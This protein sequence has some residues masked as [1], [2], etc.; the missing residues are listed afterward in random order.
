MQTPGV[1]E[2]PID[3]R[4]LHEEAADRLRAMITDGRLPAGARLN[5]RVLC[6]QL[7]V[8]RTPLR[9][10]F[11]RLA[12]ER[13]IELTPNRGARVIALARADVEELFE[14][15]GALEGLSGE[16]AAQRRSEAEL[17][18]IR[19]LHYEMLAAHARRD[20]PAYYAMNQR[21]HDAL[22][23]CARNGA[24][25]ETYDSINTRIQ[26]L[27]FRSNFD[28]AKWAVAVREHQAMLDALDARDGARLRAVLEQHLRTKC[29]AVLAHWNDGEAR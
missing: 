28:A 26:H 1:T 8:S 9:E 24:L 23:R 16:L 6:D 3:R 18:E 29:D 17:A 12:A 5:E 21:I 19:A 4:P 15:M 11:K 7:R 2:D 22:N 10:A 25:T 27:R 20:L 14:L 13:L